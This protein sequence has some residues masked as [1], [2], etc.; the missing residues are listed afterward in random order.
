LLIVQQR[1]RYFGLPRQSVG[2]HDCIL[3]GLATALAQV[4]GHRV[5]GV[6]QQRHV[7]VD[8]PVDRGAVED[9]GPDDATRIGGGDQRG[10]GLVPVG[11]AGQQRGA[12]V[13]GVALARRGVGRREPVH[14]ATAD[15]DYA[16]A[17]PGSPAFGEAVDP[18]QID[19]VR[20]A[21]PGGVAGVT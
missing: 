11:E 15:R 14:P 9:V 1:R 13:A 20:Q 7:A 10:D 21:A 17:V 6:A 16:E 12:G 5:G 3:D 8:P 4:G 18:S 19:V 2:K